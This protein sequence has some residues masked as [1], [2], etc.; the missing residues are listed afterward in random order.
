MTTAVH[1]G[2]PS[3]S[4][5]EVLKLQTRASQVEGLLVSS[6]REKAELLRQVSELR[7][8]AAVAGV[9]ICLERTA[10]REHVGELEER[11]S[12]AEVSMQVY[13]FA[14]G[15]KTQTSEKRNIPL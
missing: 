1:G 7:E 5:L 8:K 9:G 11:L 3:A 10:A 4:P 13:G 2:V 15:Q 12:A 6:E 14:F